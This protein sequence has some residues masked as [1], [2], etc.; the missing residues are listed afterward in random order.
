[1]QLN[2]C[3]LCLNTF[4]DNSLSIDKPDLKSQM[5]KVFYFS[6]IFPFLFVVKFIKKRK[7]FVLGRT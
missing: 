1:M 2:D 3:C 6:V 4:T 7:I 5:D